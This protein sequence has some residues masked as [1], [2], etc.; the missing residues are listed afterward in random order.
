MKVSTVPETAPG[1]P[2][3]DRYQPLSHAPGCKQSKRKA[4]SCV[5]ASARPLSPLSL[6][7]QMLTENTS[8]R[9]DRTVREKRKPLA[10]EPSTTD[11]LSMSYGLSQEGSDA[12]SKPVYS[13]IYTNPNLVSS[14]WKGH[15]Y[16]GKDK[17]RHRSNKHGK[18]SSGGRSSNAEYDLG[19][20]VA[21]M[22]VAGEENRKQRVAESISNIVSLSGTVFSA[23]VP[24]DF[25]G[26]VSPRYIVPGSMTYKEDATN[27][28]LLV[29][30]FKVDPAHLFRG[31]FESVETVPSVR[32]LASPVQASFVN[33]HG[34]QDEIEIDP[35]VCSNMSDSHAEFAIH[36][37]SFASTT[38]NRSSNISEVAED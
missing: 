32:S 14:A 29:S 15:K 12:L 31:S 13:F 38:S 22:C 3:G 11:K 10:D 34:T 25:S 16:K 18:R 2:S 19:P 30:R 26:T 4:S 6:A 36:L 20:F 23:E 17:S 37:R 27:P 8:K 24:A 9:K 5:I 28:S 1:K 21:A 35:A 7:V 33:I